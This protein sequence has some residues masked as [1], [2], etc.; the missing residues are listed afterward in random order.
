[1]DVKII[2]MLS[3]KKIK[4][5]M[6]VHTTFYKIR[7]YKNLLISPGK[8]CSCQFNT[9]LAGLIQCLMI[10]FAMSVF[11]SMLNAPQI[12]FILGIPSSMV[13]GHLEL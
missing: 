9:I 6:Y 4:S 5:Y 7:I 3:E 10:N 8:A 11:S 12:I 13:N 2:H 1:M